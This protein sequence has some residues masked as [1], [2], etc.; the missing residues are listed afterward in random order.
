MV[1]EFHFHFLADAPGGARLG[2]QRRRRSFVI[3][4]IVVNIFSVIRL[5][6]NVVNNDSGVVFDNTN[7]HRIGSVSIGQTSFMIY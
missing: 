7:V 5:H 6:F 4:V 1:L 2:N 3:I